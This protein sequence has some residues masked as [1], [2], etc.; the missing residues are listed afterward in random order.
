MTR[1]LRYFNKADES[2]AGEITLDMFSIEQLTAYMKVASDK[3][4]YHSFVVPADIDSEFKNKLAIELDF[5]MYD[6]FVE[7]C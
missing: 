2:Y 6:Y 5:E 3:P 4:R 7:Y 1:I